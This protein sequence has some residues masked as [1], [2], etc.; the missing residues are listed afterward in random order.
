MLEV[1][2]EQMKQIEGAQANDEE[3][4]VVNVPQQDYQE[5][6]RKV[7]FESIEKI[8]EEKEIMPQSN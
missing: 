4:L 2:E 8:K 6:K 3:T 7:S 1:I 5:V